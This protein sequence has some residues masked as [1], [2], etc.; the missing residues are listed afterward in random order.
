MGMSLL[1][2]VLEPL[3]DARTALDRA[4]ELLSEFGEWVDDPETPDLGSV[5]T[6]DQFWHARVYFGRGEWRTASGRP[7]PEEGMD[8]FWEGLRRLGVDRGDDAYRVEVDLTPELAT[9]WPLPAEVEL[10]PARVDASPFGLPSLDTC[11]EAE[12]DQMVAAAGPLGLDVHWYAG[13][14]GLPSSKL[15]GV[16]LCVNSVWTEQCSEPAPGN[17]AV[18]LSIGTRNRDVQDDWL[19]ATGLT[20][21]PAQTG[22]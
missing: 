20:L 8:G 7:F 22:W 5:V 18:Y 11:T 12:V 13:L 14:R 2:R 19:R 9:L 21:G 10:E 3:P 16:Q 6:V 17:H 4:R 15:C 1:Y